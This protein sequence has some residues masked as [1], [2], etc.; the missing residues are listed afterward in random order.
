M[1]STTRRP[2]FAPVLRSEWVKFRTVRGWLIGL[3]LAAVLCATF[4]F[5]VANGNNS[6]F[7]PHVPTG[8]GGEAVADTYYVLD[9]PLTG[10]GTVTARITSLTGVISTAPSNEAASQANPGDAAS[11]F[12]NTRPGLAGW[13]KA[14]ILLTPSTAQGSAYAAVMA[15]G[16]HGD[17]FQYDYTH[18]TAGSP[19]S[20]SATAPHWL[21][22]TR[23][24]D[25]VTGYD[26]ANGTSWSEIATAH[27]AALPVTVTVGL[28]TTSPMTFQTSSSGARTMATATFDHVTLQGQAA[29]DVAGTAAA[30]HGQNIGGGPQDYYPTLANG[31]SRQAGGSMVLSGSGD[32]APAVLAAE[33]GATTAPA[34][35]QLG[36]IVAL[37]ALIVIA[38]MFVTAEYRRG[39]IRTTFA[40][41]P[42]RAR[43]LGAK[44][45]VAGGVAFAATGLAVAVAIPLAAYVLTAK[46]TYVFP[47]GAA[48][49]LRVIVGSALL[50]SL[51]AVGVL[52]LATL[53]RTSAAAITIGITVFVLPGIF[54][55]AA[56]A[57]GGERWLYE[58]T[59]A[60]ALSVLQTFPTAGQVEYPYTLANGYY[61]LAPWAGLAVLAAYTG[62]ALTAAALLLKRRDA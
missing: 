55:A 22:L 4:T 27:L 57:S 41:T 35:L 29:S 19:G 9:Q 20:V 23:T 58:F 36:L 48:T 39:L 46:S 56:P 51:T 13:A 38:A 1:R 11:G 12:A 54:S 32:I 7:Q 49:D 33:L 34:T 17:R 26:S 61:P 30:W 6:N 16:S 50:A 18:D 47:A 8:Q 62:L 24:G 31:T 52:A 60:A 14:G 45:V 10:D 37:I 44:V 28:F 3:A 43:V 21:R 5:L 40:A 59:P 42:H 53:L 2:D 25:T 15:T